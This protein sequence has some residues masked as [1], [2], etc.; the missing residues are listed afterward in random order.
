MPNRLSASSQS[1]LTL[2]GILSGITCDN[3]LVEAEVNDLQKW[4]DDNAGLKGNYPYDKIYSI[5]TA[6]LADGVLK[7][8]E[9]RDMLRLF[10]QVTAPVNKSPCD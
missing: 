7:Q 1:L 10:K 4:M 5:L 6:A 8:S 9:L 3:V 2:N